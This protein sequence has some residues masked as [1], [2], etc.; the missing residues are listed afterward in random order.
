MGFTP[1]GYSVAGLW[2][3][4]EFKLGK[5]IKCLEID[6]MFSGSS[7]TKNAERN[8]DCGGL[9]CEVLE[10]GNFYLCHLCDILN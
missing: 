10:G 6:G 7:D 4:L 5:T 8:V 2:R 1:L 9:A 3:I